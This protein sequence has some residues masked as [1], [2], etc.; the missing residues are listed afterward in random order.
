MADPEPGGQGVFVLIRENGWTATYR[1]DRF[2]LKS[3]HRLRQITYGKG[4]APV[5]FGQRTGSFTRFVGTVAR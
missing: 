4:E 1:A 2:R 3:T 5:E